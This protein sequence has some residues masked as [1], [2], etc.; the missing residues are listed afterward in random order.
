MKMKHEEEGVNKNQVNTKKGT[1]GDDIMG[2]VN[3]V[4][5]YATLNLKTLLGKKGKIVSSEKALKNVD[6]IDWGHEILDGEEKITVTS[7]KKRGL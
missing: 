4:E 3:T 6:P 2:N 7:K 1:Y 5:G